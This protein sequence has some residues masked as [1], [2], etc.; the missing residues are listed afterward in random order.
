MKVINKKAILGFA[1]T[2]IFSLAIMQGISQKSVQQQDV[3]LMS[4]GCG[5]VSDRAMAEG[6][7]GLSAGWG[8]LSVGAG[9]AAGALITTTGWTGIGLVGA[10][11]LAL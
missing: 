7:V 6:E 1:M 3:S 9:V 8:V 10:G 11:V 4:W 5:A 2:M